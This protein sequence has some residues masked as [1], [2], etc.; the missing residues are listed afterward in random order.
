MESIL[1]ECKGCKTRVG[2]RKMCYDPCENCITRAV[3]NYKTMQE[4]MGICPDYLK[5]IEAK[6]IGNRAY[7]HLLKEY[8]YS[9]GKETP[10][11]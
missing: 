11:E 4:A 7:Y 8:N 1:L 6:A 9:I 3:C 5:Y 10:N 2:G